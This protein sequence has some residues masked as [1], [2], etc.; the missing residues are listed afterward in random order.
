MLGSTT[1]CWANGCSAFGMLVQAGRRWKAK[2]SPLCR[3]RQ[4]ASWAPSGFPQPTNPLLLR[5]RNEMPG[6][7]GATVPGRKG[8]S[9]GRCS[10]P[11]R[12]FWSTCQQ[13]GGFSPGKKGGFPGPGPWQ[14]CVSNGEPSVQPLRCFSVFVPCSAQQSPPWA[15]DLWDFREGTGWI[16]KLCHCPRATP[17]HCQSGAGHRHE[18]LVCLHMLRS[19]SVLHPACSTTSQIPLQE[20]NKCAGCPAPWW[21]EDTREAD[22]EERTVQL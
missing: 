22:C 8:W 21:L 7:C 19:Y 3:A 9:Q 4:P 1:G 18:R 2:N 6:W 15:R 14:L 20:E 16:T 11:H 17:G 12:V 13:L 5:L 10:P